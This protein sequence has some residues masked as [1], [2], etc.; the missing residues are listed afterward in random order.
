MGKSTPF[1]WEDA[2][3]PTSPPTQGLPAEVDVLV[4][5]AGLTGASA[6]RTLAASGKSVCVL[7]ELAPGMGAS[8]R[9]GGMVG[10]GHRLSYD[11]LRTRFGADMALQL[12]KEA[13][14]DSSIFCEKLIAEEQ[15]VCDYK[16]TGRFRGFWLDSEYERE[17]KSLDQLQALI[18]IDAEMVPREQ[19]QRHVASDLYRGGV[20]FNKHGGLNPAKWH[21]GLLQAAQRHG[22]LVQGNT[23]VLSTEALSVGF[24]VYTPRGTIKAGQ[25]LAATNGY[26]PILLAHL[27]RRIVP[28]PS[29]IIASEELGEKKLKELFPDSRMIV[30]S[31]EKHCYFRPSPDGKRIIFGA[32]AAM[33]QCSDEFA[34]AQLTGMLQQ[35]FPQ[36]GSIGVSHQWRGNTGFSFSFLPNIAKQDGIWHAMGYCGNGNTMAPWLGH[37]AALQMCADSEGE[38][39]FSNTGLPTKWWHRGKPWFLPAADLLYRARD[40]RANLK[41]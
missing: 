9:N 11:E 18:P 39:A 41:R 36:L 23:P 35:V 31:R 34:K 6:A 7:D 2:G 1:W 26:T 20:A 19:Q 24:N 28:I 30:E 38:S 4:I 17:K 29:Y 15:I 25:I 32:R 27:K 16:Q 22:A 33:F 3:T 14:I 21:N 10:G 37:K 8:S 40:I 12:L 13:H 5:G